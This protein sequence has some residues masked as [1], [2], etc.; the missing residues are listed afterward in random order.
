MLKTTTGWHTPLHSIDETA[1]L[2]QWKTQ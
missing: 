2:L 1:Q